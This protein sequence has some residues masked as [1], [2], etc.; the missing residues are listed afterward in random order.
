MD[1][2]ILESGNEQLASDDPI[3][4]LSPEDYKLE[5][6]YPNPF[7]PNTTIE[8]T[9]PINR[10][11]TVNVYNINGQLV[12]TLVDNK[13]VNAGTHR[14]VWHGKNNLGKQ[15][16]TGMYLYSLEWAGMKKVKRMTL[17]K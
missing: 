3:A 10:R 6:N 16:S 1:I 2:I 12:R 14:A 17:V 5:Q 9:V 15:V 8:Y 4:F 13:M 7:N 11:V